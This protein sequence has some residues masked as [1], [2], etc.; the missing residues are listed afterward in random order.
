MNLLLKLTSKLNQEVTRYKKIINGNNWYCASFLVIKKNLTMLAGFFIALLI[1]FIRPLIKIYFIRLNSSR[2]GHFAFGTELMLSHF[3]MNP[4]KK[5]RKILLFYLRLSA[6]NKQLL[7]MCKRTFTILPFPRLCSNIDLWLRRILGKKY[8]NDFVKSFEP[9]SA[10][11]DDHGLL[12]RTKPHL[13]FTQDELEYGKYLIAK[14]GIHPSAKFICLL[15][16]DHGYMNKEFPGIDHSH[17]WSRN[18]N[19]Q[20]YKK[21]ALFLA[22]KGYYVLRMGKHVEQIFGASHPNI[23]DYANHPLRSDFMDIYI[24]AHCYFFITTG[25]GLDCI[26]YMFRRPKLITNIIFPENLAVWYPGVF[27]IYKKLLDKSKNRYLSLKEIID[28]VMIEPQLGVSREI[29]KRNNLELIDNT[30]DE[31]L[32]SVRD[33]EAYLNG[34]LTLSK[35]DQLIHQKFSNIFSSF[36]KNQNIFIRLSPSFYK[37]GACVLE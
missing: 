23:I 6:S 24:S 11:V 12:K 31:I 25:S 20:T 32:N 17:H 34:T 3:E 30:E 8:E 13:P 37:N 22:E 5:R 9:N 7:K 33:M 21:A 1:V 15:V 2:M 36:R 27:F 16:R 26:A 18:C 4:E 10:L 35:E 14:L 19:I 29:L 28:T